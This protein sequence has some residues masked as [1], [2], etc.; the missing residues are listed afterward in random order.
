MFPDSQIV[1]NIAEGAGN[2]EFYSTGNKG[3][4][5]NVRGKAVGGFKLEASIGDPPL[6]PKPY[7]Y[8]KVEEEAANPIH[9]FVLCD[10]LGNPCVST[11]WIDNCVSNANHNGRQL[12][13]TFTRASISYIRDHPEWLVM[14]T[15]NLSM[16]RLCSYTNNVGGVKV[17]CVKNFENPNVFGL[18]RPGIPVDEVD[19][20]VVIASNAPPVALIHEILHACNLQDIYLT[21]VDGRLVSEALL[22]SA[23]WSGGTGTG[24]YPPGMTHSNLIKRLMMYGHQGGNEADVPLADLE[25]PLTPIVFSDGSVS[26][27][28][29][30]VG[31]NSMDTRTPRH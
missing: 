10:A 24:Y 22:G 5:V 20:G 17:Y 3:R 18:T 23:N 4:A 15:N 25:W 29:I 9:F 11:N 19:H 13:M 14:S 7:I 1:W 28:K 21:G 27:I 30:R 6:E 16:I 2:V 26:W 12:A 31:R 8:G